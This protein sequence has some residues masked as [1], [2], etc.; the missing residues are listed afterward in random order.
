MGA[1]VKSLLF[2]VVLWITVFISSFFIFP[3]K[4]SNPP[5]FETLISIFLVLFTVIVSSLYFSKT[6]LNIKNALSAGITWMLVNIIIDLP[7]F[8]FGPMKKDLAD[9]FT[10]IGLTY[11]IIPVITTGIAAVSL[12][13]GKSK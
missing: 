2:G 11:L 8:S 12:G 6:E 9:Y 10:D 3:L 4:A 5:F 1:F 13:S 7:L